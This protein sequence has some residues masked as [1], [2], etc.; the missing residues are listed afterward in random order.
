VSVLTARSDAYNVDKNNER[1]GVT[2]VHVH[3]NR[4]LKKKQKEELET[5]RKQYKGKTCTIMWV[6]LR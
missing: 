5:R 1:R 4:L 3:M 6:V 2:D